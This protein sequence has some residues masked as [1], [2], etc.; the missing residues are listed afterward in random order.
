MGGNWSPADYPI[1]RNV[2]EH[3]SDEGKSFHIKIRFIG[4]NKE[5][6]KF[7]ICR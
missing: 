6:W 7:L 4:R 3:S 2:K 5:K 1:T